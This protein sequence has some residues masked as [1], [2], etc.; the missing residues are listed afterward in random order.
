MTR[1]QVH[2]HESGTPSLD[3]SHEADSQGH[4][5]HSSHHQPSAHGGQVPHDQHAGGH[6]RHEGHSPGMFRDRF[7]LSLLLTIPVVVWST[8]VQEWLGYTAPEL[9]GSQ[10]IPAVLGTVVFL[11]G[12][13]VF[14]RG[15]LA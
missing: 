13:V 4:G 3:A 1:E 8:D 11:Y 12:G 14:L 6:D 5:E 2:G 10:L 9:P 7:W 15:G